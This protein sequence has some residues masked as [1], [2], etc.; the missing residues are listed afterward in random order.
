[1]EAVHKR[2]DAV[3]GIGNGAALA[4]A[5]NIIADELVPDAAGPGRFVAI[6]RI[7]I[8]VPEFDAGQGRIIGYRVISR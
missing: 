8:S 7:I 2:A 5:G 6:G 3:G 1:M 4:R